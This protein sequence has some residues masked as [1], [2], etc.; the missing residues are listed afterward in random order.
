MRFA[1]IIGN[2]EAIEKLTAMADSGKLPHALLLHGPAG[3]G[4]TRLARAFIQYINCTNRTD[5]DSCG[6]CPACIQTSKLNNPDVHYIFPI[7]K[8]AK[9]PK[10]ISDEYIGEWKDFI[11]K[12]PY[13]PYEGWLEAIEAGNSQ[14]M[15]YKTES[16]EIIRV[17]SLSSYGSG[18]KIFMIWLPEKM[19]AEAA[20]KLLKVI[21]EPFSDTLFI[22]VSN[23]SGALLPTIQS[24]VQGVNINRLS[25]E[26]ITRYI[27]SLGKNY[28]EAAMLAKIARGNMNMAAILASTEGE[29]T[30]F[31]ELFRGVMRAAYSRMMPALR[32]FADTF[33]SSGREKSLRLLSY[34]ARMIRESFISNLHCSALEAMTPDEDKFVERFG[35]FI[36]AANVEEILAEI[37]RAYED[38]SRNGNQKIVWFDFL[39]QL[40]RLIRTKGMGKQ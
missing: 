35:P 3:S 27:C 24:R 9:H 38:I 30:E 21:E 25:D 14:P 36:N 33:A 22:M 37:D 11:E 23:N 13:M 4:K 28:E 12:N 6:H 34:F 40:T 19:N 5:G 20:N 39:I 16:E 32:D 8:N 18:Y 1:D 10:A 17:S 2:R 15:I 29:L 7:V 31:S 26:E